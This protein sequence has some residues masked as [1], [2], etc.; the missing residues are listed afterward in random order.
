ML[1]KGAAGNKK[2]SKSSKCHFNGLSSLL[3][4][5]YIGEEDHDG[6]FDIIGAYMLEESIMMMM[7]MMIM[8]LTM[9]IMT[10]TTTVTK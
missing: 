4:N 7:M 9:M 3:I 1:I 5:I 6:N 8:T 2:K 10:N